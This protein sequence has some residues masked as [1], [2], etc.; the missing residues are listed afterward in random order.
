MSRAA[1][2]DLVA[3]RRQREPLLEADAL[4]AR[5]RERRR[6]GP[7]SWR[8]NAGRPS[9]R[10]RRRRRRAKSTAKAGVVASGERAHVNVRAA[11]SPAGRRGGSS[12][13]SAARCT[14]SVFSLA[15]G[16]DDRARLGL[17]DA[18]RPGRGRRPGARQRLGRG[19]AVVGRQ[20]A[21]SRAHHVVSPWRGTRTSIFRNLPSRFLLLGS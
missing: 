5:L 6:R 10:W 13:K 17:V 21:G 15:R 19:L 8:P 4:R 3:A 2:A 9:C 12:T 20:V 16:V 11:G 14:G 7:Q 1:Q 18:A